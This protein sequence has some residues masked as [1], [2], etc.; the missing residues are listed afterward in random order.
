MEKKLVADS[1][2]ILVNNMKQ[3]LHERNFFENK[4]FWKRIFNKSSKSQ[5]YF[6][7]RLQS[8]LMHKTFKSKRGLALMT[9][10]SSG[11]ET[12]LKTFFFNYFLTDQIW[13]FNMKQFLS[14]PKSSIC[15]FMQA[16]SWQHQLFDFHLTFWIW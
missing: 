15:N 16:S 6:F 11:Y 10:L 12:H 4:I 8:F 7:I 14:Y 1:F 2:L 13:W 5:Q 3:P 9:S